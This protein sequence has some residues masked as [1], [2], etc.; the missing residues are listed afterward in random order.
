M[1][2]SSPSA[3]IFIADRVQSGEIYRLFTHMFTHV[4]WYHLVLDAA[5]VALL[6]QQLKMFPLMI[7]WLFFAGCALGSLAGALVS[8]LASLVGFCGLSGVAHG[9]MALVGISWMRENDRQLKYL[10]CFFLFGVLGKSVNEVISGSVLFS[11][12]HAGNLGLPIVH[13]H[14]GGIFGALI[15][16]L[17]LQVFRTQRLR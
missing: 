7:R 8:P 11:G 16:Y 1:S 3:F 4:S 14:L 17:V 2:Q 6:W 10:G 15:I 13:S 5:A 12:V 9:L